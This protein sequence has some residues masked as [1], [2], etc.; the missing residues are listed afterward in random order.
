[1]MTTTVDGYYFQAPY[2][3]VSSVLTE[4]P[5]V[6]ANY[7]GICVAGQENFAATSATATFPDGY[8]AVF[9]LS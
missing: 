6:D 3:C 8:E 1:M 9:S 5:N 7:P 2:T 4:T